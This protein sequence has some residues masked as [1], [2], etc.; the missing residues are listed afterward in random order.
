MYAHRLLV[1]ATTLAV[2]AQ[3]AIVDSVVAE[4]AETKIEE[5][6]FRLA[7]EYLAANNICADS[8]L[9]EL[10]NLDSASCE[11]DL[12]FYSKVC[13]PQ[14]SGL[15]LSYEAIDDD[16]SRER[17]Y[18][19]SLLYGSCVRS[20]LLREILRKQDLERGKDEEGLD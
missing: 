2:L 20:E 17:F 15:N 16:E 5:K 12:A 6:V 18:S 19:V 9:R 8:R 13:W 7:A 11:D 10:A 3:L 4:D 14:F 1:V